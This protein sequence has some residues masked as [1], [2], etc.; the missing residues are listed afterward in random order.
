MRFQVNW[1][2]KFSKSAVSINGEIGNFILEK[3][4]GCRRTYIIFNHR[5]GMASQKKWSALCKKCHFL[6]CISKDSLAFKTKKIYDLNWFPGFKKGGTF[7]VIFK[8]SSIDIISRVYRYYFNG[9]LIL[10][11]GSMDIISR[12]FPY[13]IGTKTI[14]KAVYQHSTQWRWTMS[15]RD[16]NEPGID[17]QWHQ[18]I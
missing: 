1:V 11:R 9:L 8:R 16:K 4:K 10:Y 2:Q 5:L 13:Y 7:L 18:T 3:T 17:S 14:Q 6:F 15:L 12:V